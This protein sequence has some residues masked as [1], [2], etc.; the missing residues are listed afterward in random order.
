MKVREDLV[1]TIVHLVRHGQALNPNRIWY[2]R[3]EGFPL[4]DLGREQAA[5]AA[6]HLANRKI[7]ALFTSPITRAAQ[8]A[9][10]IGHRLGTEP[11]VETEIIET[12]TLLEGRPGDWRLLRNPLNL[13]Y[14]INPMRPSWG[15]P[16]ADIR[17]RMCSAI[18]RLESQH[19]GGEIV[20]VTHMSPILVARLA[21]ESNPR[22][23]WR[24]R[25]SCAPAS[26]TSLEFDGGA[27]A[28]T[29][30]YEP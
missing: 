14:F 18:R 28:G 13:R 11:Q 21:L 9:E 2:G 1:K 8:T 12:T 5:A 4:S 24:A 26:I 17:E 16:Y 27:W 3:M 22:P 25:L 29:G 7:R 6:E 30:Y 19:R 10:I 23:P 20:L 15:E